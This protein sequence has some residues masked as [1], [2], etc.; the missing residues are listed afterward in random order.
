MQLK[1]AVPVVAGAVLLAIGAMSWSATGQSKPAIAAADLQV[2]EMCT[3]PEEVEFVPDE[4]VVRFDDTLDAATRTALISAA[5]GVWKETGWGGRFDVLRVAA[6]QVA[7]A[8]AK[9]TQLPGVVYAE[10]NNLFYAYG[11]PNDTFFFPYQWNFYDYGMLSNGVPSNNGVQMVTATNTSTG[12]GIKVAIVD[13]G[14][15]YET[16]GSFVQAP[17]LA[18]QSFVSPK[19]FVSGTTHA[20]DDNGH[21]THV[22]GTIAQRTNNNTGCAGIAYNCT[23]IPVKVLDS[24]GSGTLTNVAN[25]INYAADSG[26]KVINLSLGAS[27]GSSTLQA[28]VDY[29]WSKGCVLCAATGNSGGNSIGYPARY[30]NCMAVGATRFDGGRASY[31]QWGTGIDVVAPGGYTALDQNHDG[32]GDGILQQTFAPPNYGS[33]A[34]YFF[35]GTSM[36]TPHATA[37]AALVFASHPGYTN[38]QVRTAIEST[39]KDLG[40]AGYDT[41][42]GWGL[43]NAARAVTY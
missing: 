19:N 43:I 37:V 38:A 31:S 6:G 8:I 42:F 25:G 5:G 32:Y 2:R 24:S 10:P 4:V 34:Y 16:Y 35:Q 20:N 1:L 17:D 15:A 23:V 13:T 40:T 41:K 21:G 29:A 11:T 12:S 18:G 28:A 26:A 27:S 7:A 22:C 9:L 14:V 30:T 36:A 33:F 39:C 3:A